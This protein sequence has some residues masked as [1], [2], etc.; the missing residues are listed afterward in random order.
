MT[1][2]NAAPTDARDLQRLIG[3]TTVT[4][5]P[6]QKRGPVIRRPGSSPIYQFTGPED[7]NFEALFEIDTRHMSPMVCI[8]AAVHDQAGNELTSALPECWPEESPRRF[9]LPFKAG[10]DVTSLSI[11]L[12]ISDKYEIEFFIVPPAE[13]REKALQSRFAGRR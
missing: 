2:L 13:L 6:V 7:A 10:D 12:M 5:G 4:I 8:M 3:K 11:S 9:A 1:E